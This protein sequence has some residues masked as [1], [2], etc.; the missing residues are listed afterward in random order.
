MIS[1]IITFN[2]LLY[3]LSAWAM[4]DYTWMLPLQDWDLSGL[5]TVVGLLNFCY[6]V[7]SY[8]FRNTFLN[9]LF[10]VLFTAVSF[11]CLMGV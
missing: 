10:T 1:G 8:L 11:F 6:L 2:L 9:P 4:G 3:S 7:I 5:M